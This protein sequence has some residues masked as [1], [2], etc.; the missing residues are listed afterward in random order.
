[1]LL[2]ESGDAQFTLH[3]TYPIE[4]ID[5]DRKKDWDKEQA[6]EKTRKK[7]NPHVQVREDWSPEK[8]SLTAF[9]AVHQDFAKKVSSVEEDKPHVI[10]LLDKLGF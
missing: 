4:E 1:M 6:K 10:N 7:N 5:V 2:D 8:H 3:L 9:F